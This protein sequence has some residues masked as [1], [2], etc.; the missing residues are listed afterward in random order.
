MIATEKALREK[1]S[2]PLT[3]NSCEKVYEESLQ[4]VSLAYAW[5]RETNDWFIKPVFSQSTGERPLNK[6]SILSNFKI[7]IKQFYQ[8]RCTHKLSRKRDQNNYFT[9]EKSQR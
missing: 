9:A 3:L 8:K 4:Q 2:V 5:Q 6:M 1:K 7:L